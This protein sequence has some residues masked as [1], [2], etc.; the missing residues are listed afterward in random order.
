[1]REI[2]DLNSDLGEG[3]GFDE[4]ILLFITSANIACGFHAGSPESIFDSIRNAHERPEGMEEGVAIMT[5]LNCDKVLEAIPVAT[6]IQRGAERSTK[7]VSDYDAP[8]VSD[9]VVKIIM[10]YT[11]F[12]NRIH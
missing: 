2:V 6:N 1:M 4:E 10:S 7:L 11:N 8:Y 3:A 5:G 12:I 9:K